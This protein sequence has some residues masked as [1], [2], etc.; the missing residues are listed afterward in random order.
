[1][2]EL[3]SLGRFSIVVPILQLHVF[4]GEL[5]NEIRSLVPL[6]VLGRTHRRSL[7]AN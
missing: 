6:S 3:V 1:M 2:R 7:S 4:E 5:E